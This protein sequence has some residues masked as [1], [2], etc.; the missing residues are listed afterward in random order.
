M[1]V[2]FLLNQAKNNHYG[3]FHTY[4]HQYEKL[5][6]KNQHPN[7]DHIDILA[8]HVLKYCTLKRYSREHLQQIWF[9]CV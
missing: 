2:V 1:V 7:N 8:L 9:F 6:I 3:G 4:H 5:R